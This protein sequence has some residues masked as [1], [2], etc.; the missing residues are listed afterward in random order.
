ME[1]GRK[2]AKVKTRLRSAG[3]KR[4]MDRILLNQGTMGIERDFSGRRLVIPQS[5]GELSV[6]YG[7]G[8]GPRCFLCKG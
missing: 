2:R 4:S 7:R 5:E 3:G 1:K 6:E 8:E